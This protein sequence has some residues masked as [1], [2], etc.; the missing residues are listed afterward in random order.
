MA[1]I[2][3]LDYWMIWKFL[4]F[5]ELDFEIVVSGDIEKSCCFAKVD[6]EEFSQAS[7]IGTGDMLAN[8]Q[9]EE[10]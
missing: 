4:F 6:W 7:I 1:K 5:Y 3:M 10:L 2:A 9:P 8:P